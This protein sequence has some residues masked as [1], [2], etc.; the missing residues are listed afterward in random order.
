MSISIEEFRQLQRKPLKYRNKP[1]IVGDVKLASKK[2][3]RR[4]Q[5]LQLL[6]KAGDI[7]E[8]TRQV[9][10]W[11]MAGDQELRYDSGRRA[12]YIADF[13][14]RRE[15][16]VIIEDAKGVRTN[17]YRLKKALMRSMGYE[18]VEV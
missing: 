2:E 16:R 6:E 4:W 13:V 18:I 12:I 3:A 9:V 14:Y 8:L 7:S 5:E 11:L 10:Y 17:Y 15:G 1:T